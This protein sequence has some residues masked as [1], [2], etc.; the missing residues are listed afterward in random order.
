MP[1]SGFNGTLSLSESLSVLQRFA[2][3]HAR[4]SGPYSSVL[5]P[6][7][8]NIDSWGARALCEYELD[9]TRDATVDQVINARQA[10]GFFTKLEDLDIGVDKEAVAWSKFVEAENRCRETNEMFRARERGK[11]LFTPRVE[12]AIFAARRKIRAVLGPCPTLSSLAMGFGPGATVSTKRTES[13]PVA[14]M[15]AG[16]ECSADAYASGLLPSLLREIPHWTASLPESSWSIDEDGWIVETLP[17]TISPGKLAFVPKNAKTYRSIMVEPCLNGFVQSG[18][19]DLIARRLRSIGVDI[20]DQTLNQRFAHWGSIGGDAATIDLSSAS[21]TVAKG[22]VKALLPD[23]WY[24][25]L[26]AW[27]TSCCV[28]KGEEFALEKFSSMG[29]GFTFPLETLIFWSLTRAASHKGAVS[30]YGDDIIC[31]VDAYGEVVEVLTGCGFCVNLQKSF[32]SGPFRESCGCD[33]YHGINVRPFYQKHLVSVQSLFVLHN[34]YARQYNDEMASVVRKEIPRHMRIYGPDGYGDGHLVSARYP[35]IHR[36]E[37]LKR[38]WSGHYFETYKSSGR[39]YYSPYPG[40]WASPLYSIYRSPATDVVPEEF[41]PE[42]EG[43]A[44]TG[45]P[46]ESSGGITVERNG[47][48]SWPVPGAGQWSKTLIYTLG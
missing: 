33:Y 32:G 23:D 14:K 26:S 3:S 24:R 19:G 29:N 22:L 31:P 47:R 28:Y 45:T 2:L 40:D 9:Y 8:E 42:V 18:I 30:A 20:R 7:I 12:A 21:D 43:L 17:V 25:F 46:R 4:E 37:D 15:A 39:R 11:F 1:Y 5:V 6:M 48:I 41:F 27:R 36:Y 38:G 10:M 44:Q 34:W 35:R 16:L 13:N